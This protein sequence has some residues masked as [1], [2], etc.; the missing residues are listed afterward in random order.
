MSSP[1]WRGEAGSY[2]SDVKGLN[3]VHQFDKVEIVWIEHPSKSYDTLKVMVDSGSG[4]VTDVTWTNYYAKGIGWIYEK[5]D[6]GS[7]STLELQVRNYQV[8]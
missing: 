5:A 3:R 4:F 7:G 2:G 1:S 6:D 8:F